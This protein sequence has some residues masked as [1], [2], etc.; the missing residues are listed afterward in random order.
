MQRASV[1]GPLGRWFVV[2][3]TSLV[4]GCGCDA[5][6]T[7]SLFIT[8]VDER[9]QASIAAGATIRVVDGAFEETT[10]V[11]ADFGAG[12]VGM[13]FDRPGRYSVTVTKSGYQ[14]WSREGVVVPQEG[15][16]VRTAQV[17]A[18]LVPLT[19]P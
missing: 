17:Q 12:A 5:V 1:A 16:S 3:S 14:V 2:V 19:A 9:T 6:A 10:E 18:R 11:P 4:A 8:V 7:R 13:V 15:C